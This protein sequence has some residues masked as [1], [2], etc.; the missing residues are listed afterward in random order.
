MLVSPHFFHPGRYLLTSASFF[1]P[2]THTHTR[3]LTGE[4]S[5]CRERILAQMNVADSVWLNVTGGLYQCPAYL[6]LSQRTEFLIQDAAVEASA[7][8]QGRTSLLKNA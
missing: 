6:K 7:N 8:P 3:V 2:L 4:A 5:Q 1:L